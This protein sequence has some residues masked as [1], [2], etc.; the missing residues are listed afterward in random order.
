[1]KTAYIIMGHSGQWSDASEWV[2]TAYFDK[3]AAEDHQTKAQQYAVEAVKK[4][5]QDNPE[6]KYLSDMKYGSSPWDTGA[7]W[8]HNTGIEY[9]VLEVNIF[10]SMED[11]ILQMAAG[12]AKV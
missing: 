12:H 6:D 7:R 4:H 10:D 5:Q 3:K 11:F 2:V 1:M 8:D 9:I